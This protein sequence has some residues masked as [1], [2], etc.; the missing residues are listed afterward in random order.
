MTH[1]TNMSTQVDFCHPDKK[2]D[3][4]GLLLQGMATCVQ[5]ENLRN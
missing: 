4:A 5:F 3:I 2:R 1:L